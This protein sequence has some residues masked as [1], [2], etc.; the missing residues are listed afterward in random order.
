MW[1][2]IKAKLLQLWEGSKK[3]LGLILAVVLVVVTLMTGKKAKFGG[4]LGKLLGKPEDDPSKAIEK[5]NTVDKGR[6]AP[7][8]KPIEIGQPDS[9][10]QTQAEVLPIEKTG[11][12]SDDSK[13]VIDPPNEKPIEV[14]LPVGVTS[15]EVAQEVVVKPEVTTTKVT[16]NSKVSAQRID[17]LLK[18]YKK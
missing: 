14:E 4:L 6:V 16:D 18:K 13:I 3:Y 12:F 8:G 9:K 15:K 11:V 5:A 17:D 10:G 2:W 1:D 7:D